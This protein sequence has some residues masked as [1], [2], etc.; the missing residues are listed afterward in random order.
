MSHVKWWHE[1]AGGN[2]LHSVDKPQKW[3]FILNVYIPVF[4]ISDL[5][6]GCKTTQHFVVPEKLTI[7]F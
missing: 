1:I 4:K 7:L 5:C 2:P 3:H 6:L